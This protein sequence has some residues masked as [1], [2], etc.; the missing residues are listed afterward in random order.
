MTRIPPFLR[1]HTKKCP[2]YKEGLGQCLLC[3]LIERKLEEGD[4]RMRDIGRSIRQRAGLPTSSQ[5]SLRKK[6]HEKMS[7]F[8][9]NY[10]SW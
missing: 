5:P 6:A 4:R 9:K 3:D 8:D 1:E 2:Y 7:D 10:G